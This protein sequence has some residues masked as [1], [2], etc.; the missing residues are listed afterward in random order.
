LSGV[1]T[2]DFTFYPIDTVEITQEDLEKYDLTD[3]NKQR[4]IALASELACVAEPANYLCLVDRDLD[5]WF[6]E[7][8]TVPRLKWTRFCSI[9]SHF[10]AIDTFY[11]IAVLTCK[12]KIPSAGEMFDSCMEVLR[13]LYSL[14]LA[15]S[16]LD[17]GMSWVPFKRYL[18]LEH[19]SISLNCDRYVDALVNKNGKFA[20]QESILHSAKRWSEQFSSEHRLCIRGHDF[21][22]LLALVVSKYKGIDSF[23]NSEAI[24]RL[25]VLAAKR[26]VEIVQELSHPD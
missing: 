7:H 23:G 24:A 16:E 18:R 14:R 26:N 9:E 4:V 5:H 8:P 1:N 10:I 15:D 19:S 17:L 21:T 22:E 3:G 25:L 2:H 6:K 11:E 20:D 12:A 13:Y